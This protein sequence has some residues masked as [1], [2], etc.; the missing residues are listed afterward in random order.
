MNAEWVK[1]IPNT[2]VALFLAMSYHLV[3]LNK[4]DKKYLAKYAAGFDKVEKY[5]MGEDSNDGFEKTP[6][7]A[8]KITGIPA[9]KIV[10]MAKLFASK[11]TQFAGAWSL[12]R[13]SH[14][15]ITHW[16]IINFAAIAG[17]IGKPGEGVGFSWHYSG[18]GMPQSGGTKPTGLPQGRNPVKTR[19]PA[20]RIT[21]MLTNPG[22]PF[23]RDGQKYNHPRVR[24]IYNGV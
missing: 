2:D 12:Q 17:K 19:C 15:E 3:K 20:S 6:E 23:Y 1:I 13:A 21:E 8:S 4:H 11:R 14:G 9:E 24:M 7:W 5:L 16:A 22:A 10:E 18:G